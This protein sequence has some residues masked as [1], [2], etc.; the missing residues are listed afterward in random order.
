[1][2]GMRVSVYICVV[3]RLY[4]MLLSSFFIHI[5]FKRVKERGKA[6]FV[7]DSCLLEIKKDPFCIIVLKMVLIE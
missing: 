4:N 7:S 2:L 5:P 3:Y 1:M 6:N